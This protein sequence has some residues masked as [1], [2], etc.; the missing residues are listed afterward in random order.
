MSGG[1]KRWESLSFSCQHG[2]T[3]RGGEGYADENGYVVIRG[4]AGR[5]RSDLYILLS[6]PL[7]RERAKSSE[8][9]EN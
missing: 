2:S 3:R 7:V 9:N 1:Y 4:R 8:V 5:L 6:L